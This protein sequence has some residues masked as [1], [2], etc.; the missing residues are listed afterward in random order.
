MEA[1]SVHNLS[2][3]YGEVIAVDSV[4]FS[5]N[6]GELFAVV[7]PNGGGKSTL[8]RLLSTLLVPFSG[9]IEAFGFDTHSASL[10]VRRTLGVVFQSPALD[11]LLTVEEN[12]RAHGALFGMRGSELTQR[13]DVVL[14]TVD[15]REKKPNRVSTLSGGQKRRLEIAKCLLSRP[16]LLLLDEPTTALDPESRREVW[17]TLKR[18]SREENLTVCLTT[19]LLD[20]AEK[21]DRVLLIDGGRVLALGRPDDLCKQA[22]EAVVAISLADAEKNQFSKDAFGVSWKETFGEYRYTGADAFEVGKKALALD[23]VVQSLRVGRA[24]LED[25]YFSR[26]GKR[27]QGEKAGTT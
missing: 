25:F 18:L 27:W 16:R 1:L 22:G 23:G 11:K 26:T 15:L 9:K 3:R 6:E 13:I 24:S 5:V 17:K 2:F 4:S 7:G 19:H 8:F 20:E 21:C 14:S 10:Q 12:L